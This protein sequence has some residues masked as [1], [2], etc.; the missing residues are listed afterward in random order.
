M[1]G[2]NA[3]HSFNETRPWKES[4]SS[5][6]IHVNALVA[7]TSTSAVKTEF[8]L[9]SSAELV[10]DE[11]SS[12]L[13]SKQPSSSFKQPSFKNEESSNDDV[14]TT[15]TTTT[16]PSMLRRRSSAFLSRTEGGMSKSKS[17]SQQFDE[18]SF[19]GVG[20][21]FN[22][23][24]KQSEQQQQQQQ[25]QQPPSDSQVMSCAPRSSKQLESIRE[26]LWRKFNISEG[27]EDGT[28]QRLFKEKLAV[29][30]RTFRLLRYGAFLKSLSLIDCA[31]G[32]DGTSLLAKELLLDRT[33]T[34]LD[35][36]GSQVI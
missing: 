24:N 34:R 19:Q 14:T 29:V 28:R 18:Q 15:T 16:N 21:Q 4:S 35:L 8:E 7:V 9:S 27:E 12:S 31:L 13:S 30:G 36:E 3:N 17:F 11:P 20:N 2:V 32:A 33:I 1:T 5:S 10:K 25:Q 23:D 22:D 6:S 26:K